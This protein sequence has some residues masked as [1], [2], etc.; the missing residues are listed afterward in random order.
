MTS[1]GIHSALSVPF[2]VDQPSQPATVVRNV[3][4]FNAG[5][6]YEGTKRRNPIESANRRKA[7]QA[8]NQTS[9]RET[10]AGVRETL[11]GLPE[12]V[13][14]Q[15]RIILDNNG[16]MK[17]LVEDPA[18]LRGLGQGTPDAMAI[19]RGQMDNF[20]N[21]AALEGA[22]WTGLL[23]QAEKPL[24]DLATNL[25]TNDQ[26]RNGLLLAVELDL[27]LGEVLT[28]VR[29]GTLKEDMLVRFMDGAPKPCDLAAVFLYLREKAGGELKLDG[30]SK[31]FRA[32]MD[33]LPIDERVNTDAIESIHI[34]ADDTIRVKLSANEPLVASPFYDLG[35]GTE[36]VIDVEANPV[37][38]EGAFVLSPRLPQGSGLKAVF[39]ELHLHLSGNGTVDH[40][41]GILLKILFSPVLLIAGLVVDSSDKRYVAVDTSGVA[42]VA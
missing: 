9:A 25:E 41:I 8:K 28:D 11:N 15:A 42:A 31:T 33:T 13:R 5:D 40:L 3:S 23:S 20:V 34:A 14:R 26:L 16:L 21:R 18:V 38:G 35:L 7:H 12:M 27:P 36:L 6:V 24:D 32:I 4:S 22:Y 29:T 1:I 37:E 10:I 2:S 17:A 19:V 30:K 39:F